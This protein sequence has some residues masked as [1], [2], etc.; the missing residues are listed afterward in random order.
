M[1][2]HEPNWEKRKNS[3]PKQKS[4]SRHKCLDVGTVFKDNEEVKSAAFK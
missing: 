2:L 4:K 3:I 1:A